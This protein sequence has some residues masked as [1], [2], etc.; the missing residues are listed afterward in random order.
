MYFAVIYTC[1][2]IELHSSSTNL[3]AHL[4]RAHLAVI[5][6]ALGKL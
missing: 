5:A 1:T 3:V 2:I 4:N 6:A